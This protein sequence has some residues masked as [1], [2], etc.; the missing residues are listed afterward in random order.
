MRNDYP[1]QQAITDLR[2]FL[3]KKIADAKTLSELNDEL[4]AAL[5][6]KTV[7]MRYINQKLFE[8]RKKHNDYSSFTDCERDMLDDLMHFWG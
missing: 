5:K 1:Y 6:R 7:P 4:D 3:S 8:Y 2:A